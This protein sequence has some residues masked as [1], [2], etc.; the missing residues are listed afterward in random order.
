MMKI[1]S[2]WHLNF[3]V[4]LSFFIH[5]LNAACYK[6]TTIY[7]VDW[8]VMNNKNMAKNFNKTTT[9]AKIFIPDYDIHY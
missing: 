6:W 9:V 3:S 8:N 5:V 2:G 4:Y 7:G 1:S